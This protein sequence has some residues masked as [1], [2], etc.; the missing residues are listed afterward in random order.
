MTGLTTVSEGTWGWRAVRLHGGLKT[1]KKNSAVRLRFNVAPG[2]QQ[3]LNTLTC[4]N[5]QRQ[6]GGRRRL[7]DLVERPGARG[8]GMFVCI[9]GHQ[10]MA[11]PASRQV[12]DGFWSGWRVAV[13]CSFGTVTAVSTLAHITGASRCVETRITVRKKLTYFS[14]DVFLCLD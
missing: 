6:R 1:K 10:A 13:S 9:S 2:L 11:S 5:H 8:R 14:S 3:H 12:A 4:R 7:D